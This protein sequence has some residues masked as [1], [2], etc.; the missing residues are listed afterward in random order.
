HHVTVH[1]VY[2]RGIEAANDVAN[3]NTFNFHH[4]IINGVE[5]DAASIGILNYG[6][7]GQISNNTITNTTLGI[8]TNYSFGTGITNNAITNVALGTGIET[9]NNGGAGGGSTADN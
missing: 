2:S 6:D 1:D 8:A 3:T 7:A 4:N 9:D 5:G